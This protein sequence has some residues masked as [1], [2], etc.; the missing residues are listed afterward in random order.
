MS[1]PSALQEGE[2]APGLYPGTWPHWPA[3][4]A[5]CERAGVLCQLC[6]C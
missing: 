2:V 4:F 3:C 5:R 6:T 1:V